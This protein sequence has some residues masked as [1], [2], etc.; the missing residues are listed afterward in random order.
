M[1]SQ[2]VNESSADNNEFNRSHEFE[3]PPVMQPPLQFNIPEIQMPDTQSNHNDNS[4]DNSSGWTMP[5]PQQ[6]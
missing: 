2:F 4:K 3:A 1:L 5:E 6:Q